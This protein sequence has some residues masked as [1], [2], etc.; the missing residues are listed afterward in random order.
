[1]SEIW[2]KFNSEVM[3]TFFLIQQNAQILNSSLGLEFQV[4]RLDEISVS[5]F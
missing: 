2:K 1:M 3:M 4:S 5:K